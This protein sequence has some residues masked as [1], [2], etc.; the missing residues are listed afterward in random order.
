MNAIPL[1]DRLNK[2]I[3]QIQNNRNSEIPKDP[4]LFKIWQMERIENGL[5]EY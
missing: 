3:S 2:K 5:R 1:N 4:V